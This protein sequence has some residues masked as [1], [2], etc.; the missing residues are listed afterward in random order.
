M[1]H[2]AITTD[3]IYKMSVT[4]FECLSVRL[5]NGGKV[6]L[7][8]G[9]GSGKIGV[10]ILAHGMSEDISLPR[11]TALR[12]KLA[13]SGFGTCLTSLRVDAD[14][15]RGYGVLNRDSK[16]V[17]LQQIVEIVASEPRFCGAPIGLFGVGGVGT[18]CLTTAA[19]LPEKVG[20][21]VAASS[22]PGVVRGE[23]GRITAPTLLIVPSWSNELRDSVMQNKEFFRCPVGVELLSADTHFANQAH[24]GKFFDVTEYWFRDHLGKRKPSART[25]ADFC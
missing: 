17:R 18:A 9:A 24:W 10:V 12:D 7:Q 4:E 21:V 8:L 15:K 19:R 3:C 13:A 11:N 22:T 6:D 25:W 16:G 23:L 5:R 14:Q 1:Q 2:I 20:A